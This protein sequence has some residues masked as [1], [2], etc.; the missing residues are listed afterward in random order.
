MQ[1]KILK[2]LKRKKNIRFIDIM[3]L[4]DFYT[5][6][7]NIYIVMCPIFYEHKLIHLNK[8]SNIDVYLYTYNLKR[9]IEFYSRS[10]RFSLYPIH[11]GL[12]CIDWLEY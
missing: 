8:K 9:A 7:Y 1:K 6:L 12:L 3:H 2:N 10:Y 5:I 11:D 4:Y